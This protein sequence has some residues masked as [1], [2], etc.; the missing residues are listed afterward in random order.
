MLC[1][2]GRGSFASDSAH[3]HR[4][5]ADDEL[6]SKGWTQTKSFASLSLP[7]AAIFLPAPPKADNLHTF[8]PYHH[9]VSVSIDSSTR[10]SPYPYPNS[11]A[12]ISTST[13]S[14][15]T[16]KYDALGPRSSTAG[17]DTEALR[18]VGIESP[19]IS[20]NS[21]NSSSKVTTVPS[22]RPNFSDPFS[23]QLPPLPNF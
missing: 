3:H 15:F 20:T 11:T 7:V 19:L 17:F 16:S 10:S 21:S 8:P 9:T 1:K 4:W 22:S 23:T 18:S 13:S 12:S 6:A 2:I 5:K 14:S